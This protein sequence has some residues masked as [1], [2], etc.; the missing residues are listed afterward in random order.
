[1]ELIK[2]LYFRANTFVHSQRLTEGSYERVTG[3]RAGYS[4]E[5]C[6]IATL[7]CLFKSEKTWKD[8]IMTWNLWLHS[9]FHFWL[10][11]MVQELLQGTKGTFPWTRCIPG[12]LWGAP[13]GDSNSARGFNSKRKKY[14]FQ[15]HP[16]SWFRLVFVL[17]FVTN[18]EETQLFLRSVESTQ[19]SIEI[20]IIQLQK[21]CKW[22]GPSFPPGYESSMF[23]SNSMETVISKSIWTY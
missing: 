19:F 3:S 2:V 17:I 9:K 16:F 6:W 10:S 20:L 23:F 13:K 18:P 8:K 5:S 11:C 12:I 1:M 15:F 22:P 14:F 21:Y 7:F 4:G